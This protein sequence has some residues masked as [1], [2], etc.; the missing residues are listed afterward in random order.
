MTSTNDIIAAAP[1]YFKAFTAVIQTKQ[2]NIE[3]GQEITNSKPKKDATPLP[4]LN[5]N[6]KGNTCPI[7]E[8]KPQID[9]KSDP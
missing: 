2:K 8:N 1:E 9:P 3:S 5:F 4:P 6:H 7:I